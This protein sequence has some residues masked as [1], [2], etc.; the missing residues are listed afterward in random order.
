[1]CSVFLVAVPLYCDTIN[2]LIGIG[3]ALSGVPVYFIGIH[4]PASKRPA[5]IS[6]LLRKF[7]RFGLTVALC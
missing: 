3:I 1:M 4:L 6:K 7:T 5:F 2:S